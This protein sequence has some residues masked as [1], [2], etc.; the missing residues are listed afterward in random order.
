VSDGHFYINHR[1]IDLPEGKDWKQ[2]PSGT[3]PQQDFSLVQD[4]QGGLAVLNR[5]LPE[6][7]ATRDSSCGVKLSL[8][9]LRSVG[10]LS[11]DDFEARSCSNAGPTIF[12]PDAFCLGENAFRYAVAPFAGDYLDA[13]IKDI[14]QSYR[15]PVVTIQG[16]ADSSI[17][18]GKSLVEH[19]ST[20]TCVSAIKRHEDRSTLIVRLYNL[21][22][23]TTHDS[24]EFELDIA[25]AWQTDIL[26][27]RIAEL[28]TKSDRRLDVE[29]G[30]HE[31]VTLEVA[32][33][34]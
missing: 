9:L 10:W 3:F 33:R 22:G 34:D 17:A 8:T 12:T 24:L 30:A 2:G 15:S 21:R 20:H 14:S 7:A 32:F 4:G 13:G 1:S 26:E 19:R 11:R 25:S 28:A 5:G 18:G 31:I 16:V 29:L 27:E 23:A 6:I